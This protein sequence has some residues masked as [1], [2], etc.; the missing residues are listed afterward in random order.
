MP[1]HVGSGCRPAAI[2][3]RR[4]YRIAW[5][6]TP[7]EMSSWEKG[8]EFFCS[9]HQTAALE[10]IRTICHPPAGT[11]REDVVSRFEL[12]RTLAYAGW[13]ENIHSGLHGENYFCILDEDSQ[14]ILSVTL[15]DAGNY[16]V[17]CQG[18]S[19]THHFTMATEPGV[20]RTEHAEGASG[21]SCLPAT[22][23]PQ[24]AAEYDAVWS[25]WESAA[26]AGESRAR[27]AAVHRESSKLGCVPNS[28]APTSQIDIAYNL[29]S[30]IDAAAY[31]EELKR[32]PMINNKIMNP[33]GQ[34]E[35]LMTPVSNFMNEKGFD[36]IRYRGIF[37]WD[38]PT[39][40]IPTNHFAV[41][42]NKEGKDYVF[43][44]TAH[45]F[46]NRGMSNLNGPLILSAD[47]WECKY[48]MATRRKLIYYT[49]FSNSR[50]AAYA[51]D[52]LPR[53]LESESMAGKVFVTS[54]RWFNT[55]KKQKYSLIGKR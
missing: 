52:A 13:E 51:Y 49:D 38:K 21:T 36:N 48:R 47:E 46:E 28:P 41:V 8:K 37:I 29:T 55:F 25:E 26:P 34:C 50:I 2:S 24:T 14:E 43:D 4:I 22:T 16:T 33:A 3:N 9:T 32:N 20:E 30:D 27:A 31:L 5:S 39:E 35:S 19:E 10:C 6:D 17:N 54:P 53:E 40:E 15:D 1:F 45:Q 7:P 42:G 12:L 18:Y 23:A 44:V 11:T